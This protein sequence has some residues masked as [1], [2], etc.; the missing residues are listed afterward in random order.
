MTIKTIIDEDF[1]HYKKPS[2]VI[3]FPNC[4]FKCEEECGMQVCQNGTLATIP[5]IEVSYKDVVERYL[6]NSLTSAVVMA[7]LEPFD[8]AYEMYSLI[9]YFRE[10]TNDDIVIY[11]GYTKEEI[12][13]IGEEPVGKGTILNLL[14]YIGRC[15]IIVKFGRFVP[16]QESHYDETLGMYLASD[17]QYS[18][19]IC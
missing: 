8:S 11:T 1:S 12:E 19:R 14:K 13:R 6:S 3:V 10:Y 7:G 4:T 18:E 5:N 15:N 16:N 9:G 17:N 2:M